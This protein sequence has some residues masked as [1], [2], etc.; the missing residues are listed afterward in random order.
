MRILSDLAKRDEDPGALGRHAVLLASLVALIVSLPLFRT[1]PGGRV[2]FS[3]LLCLVLT[4]AVYVN[5]RR[6]WALGVAVLVGGGAIATLA[7]AETTGSMTARI[8]SGSLGLGLLSLTTLM[9]LNTLMRAERVSKDTIIGGI[10]VY[11]MIGL[12]FAMA[13]TLALNLEPSVLMQGGLPLADAARDSS[14]R[15]AKVLYFSFVTLTT[16]GFG[17]IT[18]SG[19]VTEMMV[20]AEASIGQL[21]VAI[22][23][24]RLMALYMVGDRARLAERA[25]S[26]GEGQNQRNAETSAYPLASQ[27]SVGREID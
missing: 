13:Y 14:I 9:M 23:I 26:E 17:D 10:C 16:L 19:E 25:S 22:F 7:L 1:F 18:P 2:R 6:R 11:L 27:S 4:A 5:G 20:M 12:C 3:V 15:A 24:A 21:Y 8:A